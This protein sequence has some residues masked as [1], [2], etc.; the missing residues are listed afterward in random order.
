MHGRSS[1]GVSGHQ[2]LALPRWEGEEVLAGQYVDLVT[3]QHR[4][5]TLGTIDITHVLIL[6]FIAPTPQ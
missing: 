2:V 6:N 5:G 4:T 1:E 3:P